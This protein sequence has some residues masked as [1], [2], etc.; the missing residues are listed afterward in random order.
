M[1]ES[2]KIDQAIDNIKEY[3]NT[4]YE[5]VTLKATDK[6]SGIISNVASGVLILWLML[7]ALL[8][9]SF[10]AAW[11]FSVVTGQRYLGFC[12]VGGFY[13]VIGIVLV[14]FRRSLLFKPF[15]NKIIEGF[16]KEELS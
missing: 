3:I 2:K 6:A 13:L 11:Y 12:I 16:F 15:R 8:L 14:I 9:L 5:L 1:E 4:R 10:A 7:M